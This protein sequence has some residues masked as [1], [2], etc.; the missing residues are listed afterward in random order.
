MV[1]AKKYDKIIGMGIENMDMAVISI[2]Q[3]DGN[4]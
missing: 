1:E 3:I 4:Q 2:F